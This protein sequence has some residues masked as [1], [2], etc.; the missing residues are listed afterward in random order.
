[1]EIH[2]FNLC[3]DFSK[4]CQHILETKGLH[5]KIFAK[6]IRTNIIPDKDKKQKLGCDTLAQEQWLEYKF[7]DPKNAEY[8]HRD[9][10]L[11]YK[12]IYHNGHNV[13]G[14]IYKYLDHVLFVYG[15]TALI[16]NKLELKFPILIFKMI[17]LKTFFNKYHQE[18]QTIKAKNK[19]YITYC[20]VAPLHLL[21]KNG[22]HIY[23]ITEKDLINGKNYELFKFI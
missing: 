17:E 11:E 15:W 19:D 2:N 3:N 16:N 22:V 4:K 21:K 5:K 1:M 18:L 14:W 23:Q 6:F 20:K 12:H 9:I 10:L 13:Q 7:R 8:S